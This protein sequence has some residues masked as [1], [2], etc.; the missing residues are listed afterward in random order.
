[1][2][3]KSYGLSYERKRKKQLEKEGYHVSRCRGSFG[4]FD[5]IAINNKE[6]IFESIKSTK[7]KY[8]SF[9]EELK[10][11]REFEGM[12]PFSIKRIILFHK[13]KIKIL[14]DSGLLVYQNENR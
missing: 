3:N 7:Q 8:F 4:L 9:K 1:M 12:P 6:I 2:S 13:G 14:Y 10:K 5:I 11:I